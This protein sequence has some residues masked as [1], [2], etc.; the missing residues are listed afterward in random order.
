MVEVVA[1]E[2]S[3]GKL[4]D[5]DHQAEDGNRHQQGDS[6]I[7]MHDVLHRRTRD[8]H[9]RT[10]PEIVTEVFNRDDLFVQTMHIVLH[11]IG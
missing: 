10:A 5:T 1:N 11:D 9:Q 4:H 7:G 8:N 6:R 3:Y 2:A